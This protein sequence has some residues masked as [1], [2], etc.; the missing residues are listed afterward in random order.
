MDIHGSFF[1]L[2]V[3][4]PLGAVFGV[5]DPSKRKHVSKCRKKNP[6]TT[7]KIQEKKRLNLLWL[8]TTISKMVIYRGF[9]HSKW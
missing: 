5:V 7:I 1:W 2:D 9:S 3:H 8:C 4:P 6:P